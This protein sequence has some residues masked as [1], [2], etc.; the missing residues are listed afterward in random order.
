VRLCDLVIAG[1][2]RPSLHVHE[3]DPKPLDLQSALAEMQ[4]LR[5]ENIHL[6]YLLQEHGIQ[7]PPVQSTAGIPVTTNALPS[8]RIPVLKAE[9]RIA[10]FRSFFRGRDDVYAVR[11]E[12]TDGRSGYMPKADRDW[13]AYLRAKDEDRKKVD[14]QTRKFRPLTDEVVRGH[15]LGDHTVGIYPLLQDE[16]CWF[17]A[18]DFDKKTWQKDATAFLAVCCELNVPAVLERSRS[19]NGGHVWIFFDRA[20]PA[21][22]A[23]KLGCA[24]LTR[25]MESR[26]QLGLDSYDR[27]FPNQDTMPKGGLGNLIALPLQ[28][29]P[30]SPTKW[31]PCRSE[32]QLCGR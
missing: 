20:I 32:N 3:S 11:W 27:F 8:A 7:I 28:K 15:L 12:N 1:R 18:V 30:G 17:L 26:H 22:T 29:L 10:L 16:T 21:T 14:R 25:A 6:R 19:G 2:R 4:R 31:K 23:R 5:E 9:Q 13:K 24:I